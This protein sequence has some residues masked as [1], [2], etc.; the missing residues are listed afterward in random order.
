MRNDLAIVLDTTYIL[1]LLKL[2]LRT[3]LG[4]EAYLL[5]EYDIET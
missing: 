3:I 1:R 5:I 4:K 2:I